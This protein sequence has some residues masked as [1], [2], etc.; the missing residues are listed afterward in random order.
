MK[1]ITKIYIAFS[2]ILL[3]FSFVTVMYVRQSNQVKRVTQEAIRATE[4]LQLSE[5]LGRA[6]VESETGVRGFH[7]SEKEAFLEPYYT[8]SR[9]YSLRHAELLIKV[10][11]PAQIKRLHTIDSTYKHWQ[12]SFAER[13]IL[14]KRQAIVSPEAK[15]AFEDFATNYVR[16]G[17]GKRIMDSIRQQLNV[18]DK[19]EKLIKQQRVENLNKTLRFTDELSVS[20]TIT[21]LVAGVIVMLLLGKAIGG[22]L[23]QM[24]K[25]AD[26]VAQ[27][28]FDV[29]IRDFRNDEI[30]HVS[31]SLNIMAE[32]LDA[33]FTNLQKTNKELDQFAYVV[34]HDLKAPLRAINSLAEWIQEDL[35][36][37]EPD[38][39]RNLELMRGRAHRM[40]NLINGILE[41]SRIGRKELPKSTFSVAQLVNEVIDSLSP[42]ED[43]VIDV[44]KLLP[45]VTAERILLYQVF[46]NLISNAIKYNDKLQPHIKVGYRNLPQQFEFYVQD[47]GPGIPAAF[48][49]KVFGVFQT[50]ESRDKKESTGI[51]LAIVKKIVEEK[52]GTITLTSE[53]GKGCLFTFSWPKVQATTTKPQLKAQEV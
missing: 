24:V 52:G 45:E 48:H 43:V 50:I 11:D 18:F 47:N 46:S 6:I 12:N 5:A 22:R 20:L 13:A 30:T 28:H 10:K 29:K 26:E 15:P 35:P 14:L 2:S 53:E 1:L 44:A 38:V 19:E 39:Q 8:G 7:V 40:E 21:S 9:E 27:G 31:R 23:K 33:S 49:E 51:G 42:E 32:K 37:V 25:M 36:N 16:A 34:S 3:I 17:Y 4:V 41:Y